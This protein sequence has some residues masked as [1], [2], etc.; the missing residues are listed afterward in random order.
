MYIK[1]GSCVKICINR[2]RFWCIVKKIYNDDVVA[3]V[4]NHLILNK[5]IKFKDVIK[6]KLDDI[7]MYQL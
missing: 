4:Y 7:V 1:P 5:D 3:V 6:F 2:E